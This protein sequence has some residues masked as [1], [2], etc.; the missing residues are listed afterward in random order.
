MRNSALEQWGLQTSLKKRSY[1]D[2]IRRNFRNYLESVEEMI[3][4]N[5]QG[6]GENENERRWYE[7]REPYSN[8]VHQQRIFDIVKR[9][10][11]DWKEIENKLDREQEKWVPTSSLQQMIDDEDASE[12][13]EDAE[14]RIPATKKRGDGEK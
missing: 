2:Q 3:R 9:I 11:K 6:W 14:E 13:G 7:R 8:W 1:E 12:V 5:W 10:R 4:Q